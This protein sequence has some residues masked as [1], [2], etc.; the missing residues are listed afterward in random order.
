MKNLPSFNTIVVYLFI[1]QSF[2]CRCRVEQQINQK[3][4]FQLGTTCLQTIERKRVI[5]SNS[6]FIMTA[7]L[8][9]IC[10][11]SY[12]K[13]K[14]VREHIFSKAGLQWQEKRNTELAR[15]V[16][17]YSWNR[18]KRG[19]IFLSITV[20]YKRSKEEIFSLFLSSKEQKKSLCFYRIIECTREIMRE[21]K[22]T[23][24]Q[25]QSPANRVLTAFHVFPNSSLCLRIRLW[26]RDFFCV[27]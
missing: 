18:N 6:T 19:A 23:V 16:D 12:K 2:I 4:F 26:A 8:T 24:S 9:H 21:V 20:Y 25:N 13:G 27:I 7:K 17:F 11:Y 14:Q 15:A 3:E 5:I 22:R 10:N 1:T